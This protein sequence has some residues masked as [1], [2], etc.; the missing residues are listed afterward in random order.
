MRKL[1]FL[2]LILGACKAQKTSQIPT[3]E[4]VTQYLGEGFTAIPNE[5]NTFTLY[6]V[7]S[8]SG[9]NYPR[10]KYIIYDHNKKAVFKKGTIPKGSIKWIN[11]NQLELY[12]VPGM[13][14]SDDEP[15]GKTII[16]VTREF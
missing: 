2:L 7:E 10:V 6:F 12:E 9:T 4:E 5:S 14:T 3:A 16:S 11:N 15:S 13:V 8:E 1:F